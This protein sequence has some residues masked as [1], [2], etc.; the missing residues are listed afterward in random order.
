ML[1][2]AS[3]R[4]G[5]G[6][7]LL[8]GAVDGSAW[9]VAGCLFVGLLGGTLEPSVVEDGL[10][11]FSLAA[12]VGARRRVP[13]R[14][15]GAPCGAANVATGFGFGAGGFG[16]EALVV[17]GVEA[18]VGGFGED[19]F[20]DVCVGTGLSCAR[21]LSSAGFLEDDEPYATLLAL[22]LADML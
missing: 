1:V 17:G 12:N 16:E 7:A 5:S 10:S 13:C 8:L 11:D 21:F 19:G 14:T 4:L 18:D 9:V 22:A 2:K 15:G 3:A 6:W 20:G